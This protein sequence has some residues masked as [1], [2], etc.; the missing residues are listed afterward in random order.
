MLWRQ[1]AG[2]WR[3]QSYAHERLSLGRAPNLAM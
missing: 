2:W 3:T 1:R